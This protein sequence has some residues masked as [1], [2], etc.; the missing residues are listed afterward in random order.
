MGYEHAA[1]RYRRWYAKLLRFYPRPFRERFGSGM[2]QTFNDLVRERQAAGGELLGFV[3]RV[4]VETFMGVIRE[5]MTVMITT[6]MKHGAV[7]IS[8]FTALAIIATAL[9]TRDTEYENAWFIVFCVG[10]VLSAFFEIY[11][12]KQ[13]RD[14]Q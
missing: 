5:N 8:L 2:E 9:L 4:F 7:I 10:S 3:L 12:R 14:A 13:K 11:S 1:A 6:F